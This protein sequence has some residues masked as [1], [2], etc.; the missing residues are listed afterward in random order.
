MNSC[1]RILTIASVACTI[2]ECCTDK[3]AAQLALMFN[4]LG[5]SLST[6]IAGGELFGPEEEEEAATDDEELLFFGTQP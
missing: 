1:E 4:Y 2:V 3:E 5:A 6:L